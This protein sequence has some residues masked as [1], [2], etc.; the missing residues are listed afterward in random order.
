MVIEWGVL[1]PIPFLYSD[2]SSLMASAICRWCRIMMVP[3][4]KDAMNKEGN[5]VFMSNTL[6]VE[7]TTSPI[8]LRH[9]GHPVLSAKDIP[10]PS[11][12]VF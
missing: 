2:I 11:N 12:L 5:R 4:L 6:I 10:Y 9:P 7:Q 3:V 1:L 8:I